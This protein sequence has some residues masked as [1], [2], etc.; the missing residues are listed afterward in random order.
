M[1]ADQL[2]R[3]ELLLTRQDITDCLTRFCRGMDR[4]DRDL[5]LS[6]FHPD[7]EIAAGDFVGGPAD[8]YEWAHNMH[9]AG[10][11][12]HAAQLAQQHLRRRWRNR[13]F[14]NLLSIRCS[15]PR[16]IQLD[17]RWPLLRPPRA[18]RW[19]VA[20]NVAH[21]RDRMVRNA[22]DHADTVRRRTR[23][24]S[25]RRFSTG[26]NR[27]VLPEATRQPPRPPQPAHVRVI[28]RRGRRRRSTT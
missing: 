28:H 27:P 1:D 12:R 20:D 3:F 16:R 15:Q 10:T 13:A 18:S 14:R 22:A 7:A 6:A 21:Q 26:P 8:L 5:F 17:R 19:P 24:R 11:D 25:Q 2:A 4:F 9:D 23:H